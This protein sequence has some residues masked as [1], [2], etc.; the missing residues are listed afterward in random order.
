[1]NGLEVNLSDSNSNRLFLPAHN[2]RI[3]IFV[4]S[5]PF[6]DNG[7]DL[8]NSAVAT[9]AKQHQ[10]RQRK[11]SR[12]ARYSNSVHPSLKLSPYHTKRKARSA[13]EAPTELSIYSLSL[14]SL[15]W[16]MLSIKKH[17]YTAAFFT[18]YACNSF[19]QHIS[20]EGG[21]ENSRYGNTKMLEPK[22]HRKSRAVSTHTSQ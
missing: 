9:G 21:R 20:R 22:W 8:V 14:Q 4:F 15:C 2:A 7:R 10:T 5:V 13:T 18:D 3:L 6:Y 11:P 16:P 19:S 17:T 1:M 12:I